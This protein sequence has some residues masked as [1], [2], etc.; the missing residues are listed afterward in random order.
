MGS[1]P[2]VKIC[3]ITNKRDAAKA[4]ELG[5]P[6]RRHLRAIIAVFVEAENLCKANVLRSRQIED[7]GVVRRARA[8]DVDVGIA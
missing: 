5:C 4:V 1:V 6:L 7:G 8:A 2:R 3:G